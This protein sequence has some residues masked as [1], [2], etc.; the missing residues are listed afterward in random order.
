M[1]TLGVQGKERIEGGNAV[2]LRQGDV[3][4]VGNDLLHLNGQVA[5]DIL[6][7]LHHRHGAALY[8]LIL[9]DDGLQLGFLLRRTRKC[10]QCFLVWH[11]GALL[12]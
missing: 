3:Q 2:D 11:I 4:S 10:N 5:V 7:R 8:I 1:L 9:L 6:S 12:W